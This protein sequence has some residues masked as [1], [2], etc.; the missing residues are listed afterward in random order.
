MNRGQDKTTIFSFGA[1]TAQ[2]VG[3]EESGGFIGRVAVRL[4]NRDDVH[5]ENCGNGGHTTDQMI[6]HLGGLPIASRDDI[7]IVTLGINDVPRSPDTDPEKRIP[8]D[9]HKA[10]VRTMLEDLVGRCRVLYVTQFPV[11]FEGRGL[12]RQRVESYVNV[13]RQ[14]ARE[15]GADVLDIHLVVDNEKYRA[16]IHEDGM[17]FNSA[18]HAYIADRVWKTIEP[19][20]D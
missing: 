12:E 5:V 4:A 13:G 17:H 8:I 18:G 3:D 6:A 14:V 2:G 19:W 7:A 10:N 15:T 16:F 11:D 1:S 20:L 9:R